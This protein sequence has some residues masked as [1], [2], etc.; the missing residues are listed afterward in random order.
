MRFLMLY[1]PGKRPGPPSPE[2]MAVVE[3]FIE[4]A[5][6]A[7]VLV[8]T[9]GLEAASKAARIRFSAGKATVTDGPFAESKELVGGFAIIQAQS[10]EQA[11]ETAIRFLKVAGDGEVE[12]RGLMGEEE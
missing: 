5:T 8:L 10:K 7:G 4:D 1:K 2:Y 6:K 9:G 3:K 11:V 12:V